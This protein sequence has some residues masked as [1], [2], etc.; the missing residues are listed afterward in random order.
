MFKCKVCT[1]KDKRIEDLLSQITYLRDQTSPHVLNAVIPSHQ[2]EANR[3]MGPSV[4]E[5]AD[6]LMS[7]DY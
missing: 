1:E 2:E 6:Q 4:D 5:E 3:L 7:G